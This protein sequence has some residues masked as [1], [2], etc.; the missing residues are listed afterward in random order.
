[1]HRRSQTCFYGG[2]AV[3]NYWSLC[4]SIRCLCTLPT[5]CKVSSWRPRLPDN[6]HPFW[7]L[8]VLQMCNCISKV[9]GSRRLGTVSHRL[10]SSR[11]REIAGAS[12]LS[13]DEQYLGSISRKRP[14][15]FATSLRYVWIVPDF[16][17]LQRKS[18]PVAR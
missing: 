17:D 4:A 8:L 18:D 5:C 13:A 3:G 1:M 11:T 14:M 9:N 2:S 10:T 7:N 15:N 16:R 6:N 12:A